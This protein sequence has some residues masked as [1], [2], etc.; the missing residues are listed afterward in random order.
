MRWQRANRRKRFCWLEDLCRRRESTSSTAPCATANK[1]PE[2][3]SR[4]PKSWRSRPSLAACGIPELEAGT[5]AIDEEERADLH[6]IVDLRLPCRVTR[7]VPRHRRRIC[8]HAESCGVDSVHISFPVSPILFGA[9]GKEE[10]WLWSSSSGNRGQCARPLPVRVRGC[11]GRFARGRRAARPVCPRR[12]RCGSGP[13]TRGGHRRHLEPPS[14]VALFS[15]A[16]GDCRGPALA[17]VSR[18]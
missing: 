8:E 6:A 5:P 13:D 12:Q 18:A 15:Q 10:S 1:R 7:L 17:R 4:G 2:W 3:S 14:G 9:F 11:A 16:E